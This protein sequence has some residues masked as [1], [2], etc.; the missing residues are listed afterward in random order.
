MGNGND[1]TETPVELLGVSALAAKIGIG[2][3]T[4]SKHAAAGKIPIAKR[5]AKD[6]PLFDLGQVLLAR[7]D[8]NELMRRREG[9]AAAA[10]SADDDD[11]AAEGTGQRDLLE[12]RSGDVPRAPSALQV[13]AL[14]EKQL[15]GRKLI[16]ELAARESVTVLKSVVDLDQT[17]LARRTRDTVMAFLSDKA[18]AAYAFAGQSRTE[19][20]W[21]IWLTEQS[22]EAFNALAA[23]LAVED[24][25]EFD[26]DR[27]DDGGLGA[28]DATASP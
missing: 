19:A 5:D 23:Q 8:L 28:S 3:S 16:G 7:K 18:S 13:A 26:G 12:R 10:D 6:R 2:K 25:D 21:R 15:K 9:G 17:T 20:E 24:D 27:D 11:Y 1:S 22:R 14:T 4:I